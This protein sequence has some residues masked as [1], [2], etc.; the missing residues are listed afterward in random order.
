MGLRGSDIKHC[1][2]VVSDPST[3]DELIVLFSRIHVLSL[4]LDSTITR[5][6]L[7]FRL[8]VTKFDCHNS[9]ASVTSFAYSLEIVAHTRL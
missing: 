2:P 1:V 7:V 3:R 4:F 9:S 5:N 6:Y 8:Y